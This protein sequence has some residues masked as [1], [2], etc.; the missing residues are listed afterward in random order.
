MA[1]KKERY[2]ADEWTDPF[3]EYYISGEPGKAYKAYAWQTAIGLQDVDKLQPSE[4]LLNTAK[5][6]IEGDI[7]IED[8][9][10]RIENYYEENRHHQ[11]ERTEEADKVSVR[12]AE[13]LSE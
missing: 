3:A 10:L 13:I 8:A 6:N 5:D 12:I 2:I 4:Y 11:S 1:D 9:R 7:S